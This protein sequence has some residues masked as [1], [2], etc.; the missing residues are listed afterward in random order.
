VGEAPGF[1]L[2]VQSTFWAMI[3]T[4][5]GESG[6]RIQKMDSHEGDTHDGGGG[7]EP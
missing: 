4:G 1:S 6:G 5:S 3:V 7:F 2:K